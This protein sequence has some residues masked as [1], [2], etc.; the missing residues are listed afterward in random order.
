MLVDR[1]SFAALALAGLWFVPAATAHAAQ[2]YDNC[3]G[4][5]E[6]LPVAITTQGTW[7]LRGDLSTA[8][9][10]GEAIAVQ[11]NNVTID[12]NDFKL[13]GLAAGVNSRA[14]GIYALNRQNITV[15]NCAVRG[16]F[17]G[18]GL[19]NGGGHL[20]EHNRVDNSLYQGIAVSGDGSVVRGNLVR[21]TGGAPENAAYGAA[22]AIIASA[23]VIDNTVDGVYATGQ[24]TNPWGISVQLAGAEVRGNR[25]RRMVPTGVGQ[26][27]ALYGW[28]EGITFADNR[29]SSTGPIQGAGIT[30]GPQSFCTGNTVSRYSTPIQFC[31]DAG[32]NA[33]N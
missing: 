18:I 30:G 3:T 11:A 16:F 8:M 26:A 13:G 20:V 5:I 6:S 33:S 10:A 19:A 32:G 25:V 7:C 9:T 4:Y 27:M 15:R 31:Q 28:V 23:D 12:C 1:T 2:S 21:D 14:R 22:Y 24:D 17:T 29:V